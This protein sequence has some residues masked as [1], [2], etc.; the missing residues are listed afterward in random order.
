MGAMN[1]LPT[2]CPSPIN[3]ST[4]FLRG[5]FPHS[6]ATPSS[7]P[8]TETSHRALRLAPGRRRTTPERK[9]RYAGAFSRTAVRTTVRFTAIDA[10]K[11][12]APSRL[13]LGFMAFRH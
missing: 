1:P 13:D 10:G 9:Q 11:S 3:R 8:R 5:H 2:I 6:A 4:G 12:S 7:P